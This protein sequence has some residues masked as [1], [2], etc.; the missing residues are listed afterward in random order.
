M[1]S[2]ITNIFGAFKMWMAAAV[3]LVLICGAAYFYYSSTQSTIAKLITQN[4]QLEANNK[5][6]VTANN[7]NLKTIDTL[8]QSYNKIQSDYQQ[9]ES[10]FQNIRNQN[11]SILNSIMN[12]DIGNLSYTDTKNTEIAINKATAY[13]NRCLELLSGAPLLDVEKNAKTDKE[14]NPSCPWLFSSINKH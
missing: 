5:Q 1:L 9:T 12:S 3:L 14:F 4:S 6:L 11:K 2:F 7:E 10:A 13:S 8:Q